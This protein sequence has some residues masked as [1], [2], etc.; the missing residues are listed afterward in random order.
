MASLAAAALG[1]CA[2]RPPTGAPPTSTDS[3]TVSTGT[4]ESPATAVTTATPTARP[5]PPSSVDADWP[6]PAADP[7]R[8]SA[9]L[10]AA[11]PTDRPAALW[12]T[13]ADATLTQPV[14]AGG[15]LYVGASDGRLLAFDARTGDRRWERPVGAPAARPWVL[16]GSVYAPTADGVVAFD[17]GG[18]ERWRVPTPNR[19]GLAVASHGLYWLADGDAATVVALARSDGSERWRFAPSDQPWPAPP[20]VHDGT[21]FVTAS[22]EDEIHA[23]DAETGDELWSLDGDRHVHVSPHLLA[24][25]LV[26]EPSVLVGDAT[27]RVAALDPATGDAAWTVD[28]FGAV[29]AFAYRAPM[30]YVGTSSGEVSVFLTEERER[31]RERWRR[32]VDG[33]I[34]G[35]APTANGVAVSSFGGPLVNLNGDAAG[36]PSWTAE[37]R[38]AGSTPVHAGSWFYSVGYDAASA[39][40]SYDGEVGWRADAPFG[41]A[42]PVAA[43]DTLYT[44]GE[45]AVHAFDLDGGGPLSSG[46]RFSHPVSGGGIQGLA[47]ADGALFVARQSGEENG[48]TL[49]CLE[50]N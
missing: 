34:E 17:A 19:A 38:R 48:T 29:R 2:A 20:A 39:T 16:D 8:S 42:P 22:D 4:P 21:V 15:A 13:E 3:S 50:P 24:G 37:E 47:V 10:D 7:G 14:L 41:S 40:R 5:D 31:P 49:Y 6:M 46:K 25:E 35:I 18:T 43:G 28:L 30:L 26:N 44:A 33:A 36:A 45:E 12:E 23:L 32:Q 11:G 1:G 9:V 27:G